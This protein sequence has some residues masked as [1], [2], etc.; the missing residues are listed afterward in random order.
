MKWKNSFILIWVLEVALLL[1]LCQWSCHLQE[2]FV[3]HIIWPH[4][5]VFPLC[6]SPFLLSDLFTSLTRCLH[7]F[8]VHSHPQRCKWLKY[9][10]VWP[11]WPRGMSWSAAYSENSERW[12]A[13]AESYLAKKSL[14]LFF[15]LQLWGM[16][17]SLF[18][19]WSD[20]S[21]KFYWG[22]GQAVVICNPHT[23]HSTEI[24]II[25]CVWF[26]RVI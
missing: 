8:H 4:K 23:K 2:K 12:R 16:K 24:F 26:S 7:S 22:C 6:N 15:P 17:N 19:L 13:G 14:S 9:K 25:N 11:F 21:L 20:D 1:C 3:L 10:K 18:Y 5:P